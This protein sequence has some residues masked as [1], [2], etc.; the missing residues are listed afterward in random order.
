[1]R[2]VNRLAMSLAVASAGAPA[3]LS[4]FTGCG[5]RAPTMVSTQVLEAGEVARVGPASVQASLVGEI[6]R[7]QGVSA[8]VAMAHITDDALLAERARSLGLVDDPAVRVACNAALA[9]RVASYVLDA[10]RGEGPPTDDELAKVRIIHALVPRTGPATDR[11]RIAMA[12]AIRQAVLGST[13]PEDFERRANAVPHAGMLLKVERLPE[14]GADGA[15][16]DGQMDPSFVA[17]AFAL[18]SERDISPVVETPFGWHVL[19]LAARV[20]PEASSVESRR[21]S[22]ADAVVSMRARGA[23]DTLL[24][25]R[26]ART[27]VSLAPE[28]DELTAVAIAAQP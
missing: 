4:I 20:A 19:D 12:M 9:R 3:G 17:A 18:R 14:F 13:S 21:H 23:L 6:A 1:M 24:R 15:L 26:R 27:D 8:R 5:H 11:A 25:V 28:A 2:F 7:A 10:A 16:S 22:L